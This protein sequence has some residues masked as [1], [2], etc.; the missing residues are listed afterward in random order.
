MS[1]T[2]QLTPEQYAAL[3]HDYPVREASSEKRK[4][5]KK[6]KRRNTNTEQKR[7]LHAILHMLAGKFGYRLCTEYFFAKPRQFRFDFAFP[8]IKL[9]IEYE[10]LNFRAYQKNGDATAK[11]RHITIGGFT[12]DCEKYNLAVLNGWRVLRY[13]AISYKSSYEE[14]S[15]FINKHKSSFQIKSTP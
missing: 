4:R 15:Q 1:K 5:P 12:G 3:C 14:V 9:G 8:D 6:N 11:S 10:G 7:G 13:T 2:M